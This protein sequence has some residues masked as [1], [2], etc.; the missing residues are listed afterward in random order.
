M[1]FSLPESLTRFQQKSNNNVG[2]STVSPLVTE[3]L[4]SNIWPPYIFRV[5]ISNNRILKVKHDKVHIRYR[6]SGSNRPRTLIVTAMEFLRRFLQ[7]VLPTGFMKVRYF[8][9]MNPNFSTPLEKIRLLIKRSG[10]CTK[11]EVL[12]IATTITLPVSIKCSECGENLS[13]Q[14]IILPEKP[15]LSG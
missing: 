14:Y 15:W 8:G 11:K 12:A 3:C 6:K 13:L 1:P 9:F 4:L 5:A 10:E 7:H 2:T